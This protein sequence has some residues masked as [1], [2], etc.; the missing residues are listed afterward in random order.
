MSVL[1]KM[2]N[3]TSPILIS[4]GWT[5]RNR[6]WERPLSCLSL[7]LISTSRLVST[8]LA[9]FSCTD[10]LAAG[11]LCWPK[12]SPTT[13]QVCV[14]VYLTTLQV[15][16]CVSHYTLQVCICVSHY[17]LQVCVGVFHST[18][19]VCLCV[20]HSRRLN[21]IVKF[22]SK[23]FI[24]DINIGF[25]GILYLLLHS[26]FWYSALWRIL[27]HWSCLPCSLFHSSG[28]LRVCTEILR[29]GT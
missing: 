9:V 3:P 27:M 17:T 29:R 2:K 16:L 1:L 14:G 19:Q 10:L 13:L 12:Q 25:C 18:L 6:K 22:Y 21:L 7:T 8:R 15:C 5:F 4:V 28:G 24:C 26:L 11:R 23:V 20:S